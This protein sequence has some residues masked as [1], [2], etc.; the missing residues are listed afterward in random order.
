KPLPYI[1]WYKDGVTPPRSKLGVVRYTQW[2]IILD[3]LTTEDSGTYTCKA[4]NEN[5]IIDFTYKVKVEEQFLR[6]V[7]I[8]EGIYITALVNTNVSLEC[9]MTDGSEPVIDW[10]YHLPSSE[11]INDN[12]LFDYTPGISQVPKQKLN[13]IG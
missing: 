9:H 3:Y 4:V 6:K 12:N 13:N 2:A 11:K 10:V 1:I 5:G 8:K 7:Y